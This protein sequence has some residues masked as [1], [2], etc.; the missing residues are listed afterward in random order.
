M[1]SLSERLSTRKLKG[2]ESEPVRLT[3]RRIYILPTRH[4]VLFALVLLI[5]LFG[6]IN[7]N[8]SLGY[9]L[10]FLLAALGMVTMLHTQHNLADTLLHSQTCAPVFAGQRA[11]FPICL[12]VSAGTA[13][14]AIAIDSRGFGARFT[15]V[16]AGRSAHLPLSVPTSVRGRLRPGRFKV[17]S[18]FP[19][20]LFHAWSWVEFDMS[21]LVYP[22]PDDSTL[23][24]S[25][26]S[27]DPGEALRS[28][29]T[30]C[31]DFHGLRSYR[32]GDSPRQIAWKHAARSDVLLTKQFVG[33]G[34]RSLWL[35]WEQLDGLMAEAR[36]SRLT[37][38]VLDCH[39]AGYRYGLRLPG[40]I[41]EA[42]S[43]E[44]HK[45]QCL[46][47]LALFEIGSSR[48]SRATAAA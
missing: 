36:L 47:M 15:D 41:V 35:D 33:G 21:C 17:Y 16:V 30:G 25:L 32:P 28:T 10:T 9:A 8:N 38:W 20:G 22:R 18:E 40:R 37:R 24:Q 23:P 42:D 13:R 19:L 27:P 14:Y 6:A 39:R 46:E 48:H 2:P 5:M 3:A 44:M 7:Y 29:S 26:L 4:G 45:R 43:G 1:T 31:E 34:G 12:D 11:N